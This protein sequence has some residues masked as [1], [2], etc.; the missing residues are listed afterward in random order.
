MEAANYCYHREAFGRRITEYPM[1]QEQLTDIIVRVEASLALGFEVMRAFEA[2]KHETLESSKRAW[3]RL[4]T[5]LAK[6][7]TAEHA[8]VV[9][10]KA[11]ETMGGN[12]YTYDYCLSRLVRDAQV[13]SIWEGPANIQALEMIRILAKFGGLAPIEDRA[14]CLLDRIP[15][16]LRGTGERLVLYLDKAK[17]ATNLY[18]PT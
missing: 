14:R 3:L 18:S 6:Y 12:A 15:A 2:V 9:C 5:A 8:N 17:S 4:I 13:L 10:R 16:E 1:V 11:L 7:Q